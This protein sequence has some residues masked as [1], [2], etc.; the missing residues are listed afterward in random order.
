MHHHDMTIP[1]NVRAHIDREVADS[2]NPRTSARQ[3]YQIRKHKRHQLEEAYRRAADG[4]H[5]DDIVPVTG[6]R[7]KDLRALRDM[8]PAAS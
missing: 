7:H 1:T 6:I 4:Q 2:V 3:A 5:D 8:T